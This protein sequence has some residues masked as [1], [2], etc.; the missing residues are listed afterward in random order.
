MKAFIVIAMEAQIAC[1]PAKFQTR[2][3]GRM[4]S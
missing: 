2:K 1:G 4:T 3:C